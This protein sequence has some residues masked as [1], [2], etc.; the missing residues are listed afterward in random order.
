MRGVQETAKHKRDGSDNPLCAQETAKHTRDGS[1]DPL[2]AEPENDKNLFDIN[3]LK[4]NLNQ[5]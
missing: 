3:M 4:M 2:Y 1:D 5:Q